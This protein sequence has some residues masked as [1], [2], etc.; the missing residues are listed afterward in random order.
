MHVLSGLPIIISPKSGWA[1]FGQTLV[2]SGSDSYTIIA[3][4]GGVIGTVQLGFSLISGSRKKLPLVYIITP[5]S[6]RS[7]NG[8]DSGS[9]F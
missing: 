9:C 8:K 4:R 2:N 3:L 7:I 6:T 1:V 5:L